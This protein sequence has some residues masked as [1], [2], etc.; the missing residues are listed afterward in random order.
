MISR[1]A[2]WLLDR[3]A[4]RTEF[5]PDLVP[6]PVFAHWHLFKLKDGRRVGLHHFWPCSDPWWHDHARGM[7]TI[8]LRG[9]YW[10]DSLKGNRFW[11][12]PWVRF[13]P[14]DFRHKFTVLPGESC[15]SLMISEKE[16]KQWYFYTPDGRTIPWQDRRPGDGY[17]T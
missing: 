4:V 8:G 7:I 6:D 9:R 13:I 16:T 11:K 17:T 2:Y 15:W 10:E 3:L 14:A 1:I 5:P 12:A